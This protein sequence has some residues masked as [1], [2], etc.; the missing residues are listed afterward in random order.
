MKY[1][2]IAT[3]AFATTLSLTGSLE[4][5][6][7]VLDNTKPWTFW[8][9]MYGAVSKPG[10]HADLVGMKQIGLGGCYL[11]PIRDSKVRPEYGGQADQLTPTFGKW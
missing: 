9:W 2:S 7:Q 5:K 8:Y 11:M 6:A 4:A 3:L 1:K 10:I